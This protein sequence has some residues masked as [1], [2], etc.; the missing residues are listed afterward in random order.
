MASESTLPYTAATD[1]A[2][3]VSYNS[4]TQAFTVADQRG[5][6]PDGT[7]TVT[8]VENFQ[9]ADGTFASTTFIGL[10]HAPVLAVSPD[11]NVNAGQVLQ[12]A[13]LFS[14]TDADYDPLTF[15]LFDNTAAA[16]SGYFLVNGM[17]VPANT[18]YAISV[19]QLAQTAFVVGAAGTSDDLFVQASDGPLST[20]WVEFHINVINRA[21]V[22]ETLSGSVIP[23][24]SS[25][26]DS[27]R[28][29]DWNRP[30][31]RSIFAVLLD[32]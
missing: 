13:S 19:P 6:S 14:A 28:D 12:A 2:I 16:G 3:S 9:F 21:P 15:Y 1:P 23:E 32:R 25:K 7:D 10:N 4:G 20:G 22:N 17:V 18:P 5:G 26:R 29:S 24:N 8:G 30:G 27:R 31:F 11:L